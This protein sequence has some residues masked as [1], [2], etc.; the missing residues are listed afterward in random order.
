MHRPRNYYGD[1]TLTYYIVPNNVENLRC[2]SATVDSLT[3]AW[4]AAPGAGYYEVFQCDEKG[5]N[6]TSLGTTENTAF[7]V[8]GLS[9][10]TAYY[11]VA[12]GR[13]KVPTENNKVYYSIEWSNILCATTS[14]LS[15]NVT[16]MTAT[17]DGMQIPAVD[18]DGTNYLFLPASADLANLNVT[19]TRSA[20]DGSLVV[21]GNQGQPAR[22]RQCC[23]TECF[24]SG[25]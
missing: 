1:K 16:A 19:I 14:P 11:F 7:E 12:A 23:C 5:Q 17:V 3:L 2:T 8:T 4:N 20:N 13:T 21:A 22:Y 6:R 18:V 24:R 10:D 25:F 15:A 9:A